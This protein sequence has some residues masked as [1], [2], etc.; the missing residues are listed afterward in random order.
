MQRIVC[1]T[2]ETTE[3]LYLLGEE[4]RIVGVSL[5]TERPPEAKRDK[6]VVSSF[7]GA[8]VKRI[9]ELEP[10]LVIGYSD[11]QHKLAQKLV[12]AHLPVMI[13]HQRTLAEIFKHLKLIARLVGAEERGEKLLREMQKGLATLADATKNWSKRPTVYFEEWYDPTV[14]ATQWISE[15]LVLAGAND[16]FAKRAHQKAFLDRQV[17]TEEVIAAKPDGYIACWCGEDFDKAQVAKR[18]GIEQTPFWQNEKLFEMDPAIILQP[19]PASLT[20]GVRALHD[21]IQQCR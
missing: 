19:G 16:P 17:S 21:I 12:K 7:V 18:K 1:L 11:V 8:S 14:T 3:W 2:E 6:P 20:D 5:Y 9:T 13:T 10:D 4:K 15:L